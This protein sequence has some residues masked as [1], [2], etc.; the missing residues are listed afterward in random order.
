ME[1]KELAL[2]EYLKKLNKIAIA[3]SGGIDSSLLLFVANKVLG[4]ENVLALIA[5]GQMV[6]RKDNNEAIEFLKENKFNFKEIPFNCLE[7]KEFKENHKDRCYY[8]KK[9][10]MEKIQKVAREKG[11]NIVADGKNADDTREYRPGNK[12][13]KEIGIISPLEENNF[14]KEDIRNFSRI[15]GIKHWNKPSNSCLATRFPYNT[16][17]TEE[18]LT[19]VE[20]AEEIIKKLDIP[21][22]RVRVHNDIA[23]IEV[24][25]EYFKNILDNE[26]IVNQIKELGFKFITLDLNGLKSGSF[27]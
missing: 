27:D 16:N 9:S 20:K 22:L 8:C 4:R 12:A 7:I 6:S 3:F 14:S 10:I 1:S 25:K 17:L 23:R 21:K 2:E 5:N 18:L 15:L 11:F 24:E 26:K 13:T 19:R